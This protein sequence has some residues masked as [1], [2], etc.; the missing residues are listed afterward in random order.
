MIFPAPCGLSFFAKAC[1]LTVL[2]TLWGAVDPGGIVNGDFGEED[3]LEGWKVLAGNKKEG[4]A[5]VDSSVIVDDAL[6]PIGGDTNMARLYAEVF[7]DNQDSP[8]AGAAIASISQRVPCLETT[9]LRFQWANAWQL[10]LRGSARLEV[11]G[12]VEVV[13]VGKRAEQELIACFEFTDPIPCDSGIFG[14]D[15]P[16]LR[17]ECIDLAAAGFVEGES[18]TLRAILEVQG[19]TL[20]KECDLAAYAA[21]LWVDKFE[22]V[23]DC[24]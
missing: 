2:S 16:F 24:P 22:L 12:R 14:M 7:V 23:E 6:V 11:C 19:M 15:I 3:P 9:N 18:V 17:T 1:F 4:G 20:E 13:R 10:E 8:S 21:F 5:F